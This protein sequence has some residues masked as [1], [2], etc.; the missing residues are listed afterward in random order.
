MKVRTWAWLLAEGLKNVWR[1]GLM[2]LASA[3]TVAVCLGIFAVSLLLAANLE[4]MAGVAEAGVEIRV[5]LKDSLERNEVKAVGAR[6]ESLPG[7][8]G[9]TFISKEDALESLRERFGEDSDVL[10]A[11][12]DVNPLPDSYEVRVDPG[13]VGDV[14]EIVASWDAVDEV[15][16]RRELADRLLRVT[17]GLRVAGASLTVLLGLVTLI[18]ISN[19]VRL[20][21]FAR[22]AEVGIMKLVGATDPVI[23]WPFMIEGTVL[24]LIG[25][26]AAALAVRYGYDLCLSAITRSVPFLPV[27]A[28]EGLVRGV[29]LVLLGMGALLGA[30]GSVVSVRRHLRA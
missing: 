1:N 22:R 24:G 11:V 8:A 27:L 29:T 19:T 23:W 3:T 4:H 30:L 20:T 14:A 28:D 15:S 17:R 18:V 25:A 7:V 5:F 13:L 21:V 9:V 2:S 6:I 10:E 16:D 26:G 12:G